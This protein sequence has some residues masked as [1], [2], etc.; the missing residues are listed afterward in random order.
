MSN[1]IAINARNPSD[2]AAR[3]FVPT[4]HAGEFNRCPGCGR[5]HWLVGR[6]LAECA[7]CATALPLNDGGM[8]GAGLVRRG[9]RPVREDQ[10]A[11]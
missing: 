4:Y 11:A 3:G 2:H 7:F 1:V 9:Q 6:L 10:L 8:T 5:S